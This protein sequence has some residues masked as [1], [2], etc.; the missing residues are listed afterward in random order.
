MIDHKPE[1][2]MRD[3]QWPKH[4][5][6]VCEY[7]DMIAACEQRVLAERE[8]HGPWFRSVVHDCCVDKQTAYAAGLD[9][10]REAVASMVIETVGNSAATVEQAVSVIDALREET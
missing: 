9:A 7:C 10:E 8:A 2:M 6:E 5:L 1:C 3:E 4:P